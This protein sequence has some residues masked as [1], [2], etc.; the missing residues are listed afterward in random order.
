MEQYKF[1]LQK[2]LE[3]QKN[4]QELLNKIKLLEEEI[5]KMHKEMHG[6]DQMIK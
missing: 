2:N 4:N 1:E 6:R 5:K 3:V